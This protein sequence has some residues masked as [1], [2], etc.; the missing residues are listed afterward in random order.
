MENINRWNTHTL[1][2]VTQTLSIQEVFESGHFL[3]QLPHQSIVG[4]LVD[5]SVTADLFGTV[6][7]PG[8]MKAKITKTEGGEDP[9]HTPVE[10]PW[11]PWCCSL[12]LLQPKECLQCEA[13][14]NLHGNPAICTSV[15]LKIVPFKGT[16]WIN[17]GRW[18]PSRTRALCSTWACSASRRSWCQLDSGQQPSQSENSHLTQITENINRIVSDLV[19]GKWQVILLNNNDLTQILSKKPG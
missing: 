9:T 16:F 5:Y 18:M 4:I 1:N 17:V 12:K 11:R 14:A 13:D 15:S 7:I 10:F 8:D 2:D 6:S 19:V 3:F